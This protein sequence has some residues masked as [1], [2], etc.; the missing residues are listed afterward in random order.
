MKFE[1]LEVGTFFTTEGRNFL[2]IKD[3]KIAV[4][5]NFYRANAA[6]LAEGELHL[7]SNWQYVSTINTVRSDK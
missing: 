7:I 2:R 5:T 3:T 1:D 4:G 6:C